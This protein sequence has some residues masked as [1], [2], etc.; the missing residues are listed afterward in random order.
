MLK[1]FIWFQVEPKP[2]AMC[3]EMCLFGKTIRK[4]ANAEGY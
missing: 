2:F 4:S 1:A 3:L